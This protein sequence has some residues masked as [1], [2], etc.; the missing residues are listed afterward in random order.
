MIVATLASVAVAIALWAA[1]LRGVNTA[2]MDE[3][4]L[5]SALPVAMLIPFA[6]LFASFAYSLKRMAGNVA[7]MLIHTVALIVMLYGIRAV[8]DQI[9][10]FK[11][12]W[13]HIGISEVIDRTG[14]ID[15]TIDA[16]FNWPG[17]FTLAASLAHVAGFSSI[18][19]FA[20]L[21]P[22]YFN[23]LYLAPLYVIMRTATKDRRVVWLGLWTFYL[24]DW[25]A[26]DYLS[27][28]GLVF[29]LHLVVVAAALRWLTRRTNPAIDP[30][31]AIGSKPFLVVVLLLIC[32]FIIPA[33][34]LTPFATIFALGAILLS[35]RL[36]ARSLPVI[37]TV[38][39]G[40]WVVLMATDYISG[41]Q[42]SVTGSIGN[43]SGTFGQNI[44]ARLTGNTARLFV[45]D[46]RLLTTLAVW[47][48]ALVAAWR[49]RPVASGRLSR[50]L[51]SGRPPGPQRGQLDRA[52][53]AVAVSAFPIMA[54]QSYGGEVLLRVYLFV[55]P[56]AAFFIATAIIPAPER[57]RGAAA[58][59]LVF[60]CLAVMLAAFSITRYGNEKLDT[61]TANQLAA[62]RY[63]YQVAPVVKP[64]TAVVRHDPPLLV[65]GTD[66]LPWKSA[67]YEQLSH[68]TVVNLP[69]WNE[70]RLAAT[71][72]PKR[73]AAMAKV[74]AAVRALMNSRDAPAYLIL[75]TSAMND[76]DLIGTS[77][78]GSMAQFQRAVDFAT[79]RRKLFKRVFHNPDASVYKLTPLGKAAP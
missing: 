78:K 69:E 28:Q 13:R 41:H 26:Q 73:A 9:P 71:D 39:A 79:F 53:A 36:V 32:A 35:G 5:V 11:V 54:L 55:L 10:A 6:L 66:N 30:E 23:L 4:G 22:V 51:A 59:I 68:R 3:L 17:F 7:V 27:P 57:R 67:R 45:I 16:Y 70:V 50:M 8:I 38:M 72:V 18:E 75:S 48:I 60:A 1:L 56:F 47:L 61:L 2:D 42:Q 15:P 25:I 63:V 34:Q 43:V 31:G 33:H 76:V 77:P 44:T 64:S 52:F 20:S 14:T 62:V 46:L 58:P 24:L 74:V 12:T 49:L 37:V 21:A 19:P 29:F 65:A 40:A